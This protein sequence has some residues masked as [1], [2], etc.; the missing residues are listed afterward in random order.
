MDITVIDR[1]GRL[2]IRQSMWNAVQRSSYGMYNEEKSSIRNTIER[3]F[4][5][6]N[7]D[8]LWNFHGIGYH[9]YDSGFFGKNYFVRCSNCSKGIIDGKVNIEIANV[10]IVKEDS[11]PARPKSGFFSSEILKEI[12]VL[13]NISIDVKCNECNKSSYWHGINTDG[14]PWAFSE[15]SSLFENC[16]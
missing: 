11:D 16:K 6:S 12:Y 7:K 4:N 8:C 9:T 3:Y 15:S 1:N 2:G 5:I 14:H 10:L 13:W